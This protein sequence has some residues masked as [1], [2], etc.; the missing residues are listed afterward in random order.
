MP[1]LST[2]E[3]HQTLL[4]TQLPTWAHQIAPPQWHSLR[5]SQ[6]S[7]YYTQ[8][9][10]ANAA[11]DLRQAVHRSQSRLL[12]SQSTLARALEGLEQITAF[13]EPRL[14]ARLAEYGC[15]APL[16]GTE[17]LRVES[18]WHWAGMR[19]LD[20]HRRDT[21]LQAA[22]QNFADD[23]HFSAQSAIALS[24]NI[25][26]TTVQ[27]QGTVVLG[28][29]TSPAHFPLVSE[30]YEV[31]R[32]PL[33]PAA[34]ATLCRSLDLG[35]Q[36]QAHL[37][38]HFAKPHVREQ[39]IAV[40]K[41]RLHLAAD[42]AYLRHVLSG[43][44]RDQVDLLLQGDKL[45]CWQLALFGIT[46]HEVMLIDT[47]SAGLLLYLPGHDQ[48]L[49][50]C[51]DLE[52]V[53]EA[54]AALLLE[55]AARQ[56]FMAY[57]EQGQQQHFLDLLH[58]NLDASGASADDK[59]WQRAPEAD[60]RPTRLAITE[61]PFGLYQA[62]HLDR[63]KR[64]ARQLAV[65]T[66]E[67]DA[68]ARAN[69]LQAWEDLGMDALNLAG[70]FIPAVGTLMLAV[71]ACQLLGEV[72]EGYEAWHQ[73]DRHLALCHLEAVGLNL[74]LIG[75]LVVAGHV[76]PKLFKSP[77]LE[78]LQEVR[79]P[80]GRYRL[81]QA[82]LTPYRSPLDLPQSVHANAQG[83]YLHDGRYFIHMDGH[84]YE[85]RL[86]TQ[87]QQWRLVHPHAQD[88]WQP[89]L[90]HNQQGAWRASHEQPSQWSF[91]ILARRLGESYA[92]FTPEQLELAGRICGTDAA[93]LRR[94]H[95]E[96]QPPPALLLDTLQ[97]MA[98][99]AKVVA[100]GSDAPG[101]LFER[102][103]NGDAP[104]EP[105]PRRLLEAYPRL[106]AVL[107][108]R[109]L[110]PLSAEQSL[111]WENEAV[112]PAW[113]RQQVEHTHSELPLVR[114]VEG[115][116]VPARADADS[117]RLLFSALDSLPDWP[118]DVRLELRAGSPEGPLLEHIGS[119]SAGRA[120]RVIK[121]AE[122][123]EADLGQRP[124]PATRDMDLCRAVEQALPQ[125]QRDALAI[126]QADGR[127]LR[128]RVLAW[129]NDN[130]D[131]LAQR[132]WGPRARRR[133]R[134]V[135]L[136]GGRPLDPHPPHP[137]HTGSLAGAYRRLYPDATDSE[138][139]DVLGNDPEDN[140]LRSP[141]QRLRDLQQ[142]LDTLRRNLQQWARP[143]PQRLHQRQR[144]IRPIINAWRRL[145][146]V[147]LAGGGR[148]ASL[149]LSGLELENQDLASLAL[150]DDFTHVEHV[151]L[152]SNPALSQLPAEFLER[153][154][155]L[156]R[157]LLSNCR[158]DALPRVTNPDRL[159][160]LDLDN[161][162]ITWDNRNQVA[163]NQCAGLIV[164][165]LSGNPLLEAPDLH[166][167]DHLKTLFLS[168]CGLSELPL[169]LNVVAEPLVL[170]LSGNQFQRLPA[171][172]NLPGPSAEALCLE[173]EW[174][175]EGMLAQVDAYNAAHEVDLLVCE[176]DYAEFFEGTGPEQ[177]ALWQRLPLQ[178]RRDLRPLLEN[179]FFITRPQQARAEFWR[180]LAAIDADPVLRQAWLRHPPYN[181]FR[182][183]L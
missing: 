66:A 88:A 89:P 47:G 116:L 73:G 122:G 179:D 159:T 98:A 75:G 40:Y 84:L 125:V 167:L 107:A 158:F 80:D 109:L 81:W 59:A 102:L 92:A 28:P 58:Q 99:Q 37:Q 178:Y 114:A 97:R 145:S 104:I 90:E 118:R 131:D 77:L 72:Y 22:L 166:G 139:E 85:Q 152:H 183:P 93:Y 23:E 35:Q 124:T 71:T 160:W 38:H 39:A 138:I 108:R 31:E 62:L 136:R 83:Q 60:L 115:V 134:P 143:D 117:E 5:Q 36:Y 94:V 165:D 105:A 1:S 123:Y 176:G 67:A 70:F 25:Q 169:G 162:R 120:C 87:T 74:A 172:F 41:D 13:A 78:S 180:R 56:T 18:T 170:D 50:Q 163:L 147:P 173:S 4:E 146:S 16:R 141:T 142:R 82:D 119:N 68:T 2:L 10:F 128:Q 43:A 61:E 55:P 112:L 155:K 53:H 44:A 15:S 175:S 86:D 127:T 24:P 148:I 154:P 57:V 135:Q 14:T 91:A 181:L 140:D 150:P 156:K 54:L 27:L 174:L 8:A 95:L 144:A 49:R 63:L 19:Y 151:S 51:T 111:A 9:W 30:R 48:A 161:N 113:L 110:A 7:A 11:P 157:L 46:L 130:R 45:P 32:L 29:Q 79:K 106:S 21:L 34:F 153:F 149:D 121:S 52:A 101:N 171:G 12:R 103:Y 132:L 100:L 20:S 137:R 129:V 126:L 69:R 133:A 3:P 65:P 42:L 6:L 33:T 182:L 64:E 168:E 17:L 26:V 76:V 164:L 96:G 177:A